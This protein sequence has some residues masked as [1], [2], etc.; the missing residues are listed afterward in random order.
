MAC[1]LLTWRVRVYLVASCT[2]GNPCSLACARRY[3]EKLA[4]YERQRVALAKRTLLEAYIDGI[5]N[6]EAAR[7]MFEV[8]L[9]RTRGRRARALAARRQ[10]SAPKPFT[11]ARLHTRRG[12]GLTARLACAWLVSAS[13]IARS[14]ARTS[15]RAPTRTQRWPR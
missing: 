12:R 8:N 4:Q 1:S 5:D 7:Q 13:P 15:S 3:L 6:P 14:S 10:P 2:A 11:A 9:A